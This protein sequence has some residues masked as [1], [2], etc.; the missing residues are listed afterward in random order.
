MTA[1]NI[2][3]GIAGAIGVAL[4]WAITALAILGN[5]GLLAAVVRHI[6]TDGAVNIID[7]TPPLIIVACMA[8]SLIVTLTVGFVLVRSTLREN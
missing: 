5:V 2:S 4:G 3:D 8:A 1:R 7:V 6:E